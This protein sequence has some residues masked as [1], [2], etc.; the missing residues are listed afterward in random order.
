MNILI[1]LITII[2]TCLV[3][4]ILLPVFVSSMPIPLLI[5]HPIICAA[6][7]LHWK[8]N[9]DV[10]ALTMLERIA[11]GGIDKSQSFIHSLVS[12]VYNYNYNN[13]SI[14]LTYLLITI[15]LWSLIQ[16]FR[17]RDELFQYMTR[18]KHLVLQY[19]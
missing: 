14:I 6:I 10:C 8:L 13:E 5:L 12:P 16:L 2:H 9:N 19:R 1:G 17:R 3:L 7:L 15:M 18:L 11:R 4:F